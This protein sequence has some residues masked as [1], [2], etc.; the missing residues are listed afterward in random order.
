MVS[1]FVLHTDESNEGRGAVL[2]QR[3]SGKM[4]VMGME[5]EPSSLQRKIITF[6][7]ES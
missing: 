2:Y 1:Y 4:R 7:L 5:P 6:I 3:Q